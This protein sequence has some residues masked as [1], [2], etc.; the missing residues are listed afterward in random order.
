MEKVLNNLQM[1]KDLRVIPRTSVEQYR[2]TIKTIREIAKELGVNYIIEGSGQ[3]YGNR[4]SLS[5]KLIGAA[6][7][8]HLWGHPYEQE[9]KDVYDFF[10]V[11]SQIAQAIA[12]ELKAVITP[13]EKQI[14]E[15][16]S[17]S[18]MVAL[19]LY[20]KADNYL[21]EYKKTLELSSYQTAVNLYN[22]LLS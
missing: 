8:N 3:K 9:I 6:K 12:A 21:R 13:E 11:Q 16:V 15:K 5:V 1:I 20:L 10:N 18:N 22:M 17:T 14:I 19:D 2:N 4:F 7:E